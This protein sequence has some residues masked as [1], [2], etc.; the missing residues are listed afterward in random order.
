MWSA[1]AN[2]STSA[3]LL[4]FSTA[5]VEILYNQPG[6]LTSTSRHHIALTISRCSP[7]RSSGSVI[8]AWCVLCLT[9]ASALAGKP[10]Q[11][12]KHEARL[13]S[14]WKRTRT[15]WHHA[16]GHCQS[17]PH[18][19]SSVSDP[20]RAAGRGARSHRGL[21]SAVLPVPPFQA[22]GGSP[23][24]AYSAASHCVTA[25]CTRGWSTLNEVSV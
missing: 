1:F 12:G 20:G 5:A 8:C 10:K 6:S 15:V 9:V 11:G 25:C 13:E 23:H 14:S 2:S 22:L 3:S 19:D 18:R 4:I 24:R 21:Y 7:F 17:P 16:V